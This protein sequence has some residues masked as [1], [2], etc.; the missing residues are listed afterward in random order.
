MYG[1]VQ[2]NSEVNVKISAS[3]PTAL[4]KRGTSDETLFPLLQKVHIIKILV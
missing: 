1:N 3:I 4:L 2:P